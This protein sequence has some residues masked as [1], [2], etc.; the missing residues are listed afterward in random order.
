MHEEREEDEE[1]E[2]RVDSAL[3]KEARRSRGEGGAE[4]EKER[5]IEEGDGSWATALSISGLR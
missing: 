2:R 3:E 4:D 1:P 5:Q